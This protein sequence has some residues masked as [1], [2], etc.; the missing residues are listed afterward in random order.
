MW[1]SCNGSNT[2]YTLS[3]NYILKLGGI[4]PRCNQEE[5]WGEQFSELNLIQHLFNCIFQDYNYPEQLVWLKGAGRAYRFAD[6]HFTLLLEWCHPWSHRQQVQLWGEKQRGHFFDSS[7]K[8]YKNSKGIL[9]GV[10][11]YIYKCFFLRYFMAI[12]I[13]VD[14]K[15]H[16]LL[17]GTKGWIFEFLP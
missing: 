6:H 5:S 11:G 12:S 2:N 7:G 15:I 3:L 10:T 13:S 17:S 14:Q 4:T 8:W 16:G 1:R 9:S